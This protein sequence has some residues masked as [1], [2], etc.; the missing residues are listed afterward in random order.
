MRRSMK[1][2]CAMALALCCGIL[3]ATPASEVSL[4][5]IPPPPDTRAVEVLLERGRKELLDE[6][7][8]DAGKTFNEAMQN[9]EFMRLTKGRQFRTLLQASEAA[10]G[11][12]D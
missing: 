3:A 9:P 2:I 7:Y 6:K 11:R 8:A 5:N 12:E 1:L 4:A 10:R